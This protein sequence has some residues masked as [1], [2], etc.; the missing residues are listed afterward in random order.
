MMAKC[1]CGAEPSDQDIGIEVLGMYDGT[2]VI[3]CASCKSLRPR[4]DPPGKLH[5]LALE[6]IDGWE[7]AEAAK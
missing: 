2:L 5:H 1:G 7:R 6:V 3:E 4:F